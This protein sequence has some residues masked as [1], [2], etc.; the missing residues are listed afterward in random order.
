VLHAY[1]DPKVQEALNRAITMERAEGARKKYLTK[2][3]EDA[4]IK[5]TPGYSSAWA[6]AQAAKKS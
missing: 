3:R 1:D 6:E 4:Y 2:L 5:I